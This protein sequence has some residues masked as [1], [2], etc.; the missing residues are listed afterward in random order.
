MIKENKNSLKSFDLVLMIIMRP[1]YIEPSEAIQLEAIL[2]TIM[3]D[4]GW[5][6]NKKIRLLLQMKI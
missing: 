6:K 4:P 5:K 1:D 3:S 2:Y